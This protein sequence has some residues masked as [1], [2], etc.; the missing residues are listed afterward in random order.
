[1]RD[2]CC[3]AWVAQSE[4]RHGARRFE[5][6]VGAAPPHIGE[7]RQRQR[8]ILVDLDHPWRIIAH[9]R[10]DDDEIGTARR[11]SQ[12]IFN[13][14]VKRQPSD[15]FAHLPVPLPIERHARLEVGGALCDIGAKLSELHGPTVEKGGDAARGVALERDARI[16]SREEPCRRRGRLGGFAKQ[17][18][19]GGTKG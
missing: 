6:Q 14:S 19:C 17:L 16:E 4:E 5:H 15:E 1:M 18:R 12:A 13:E 8:A 7:A 9:L 3:N 11:A 2:H 10:L